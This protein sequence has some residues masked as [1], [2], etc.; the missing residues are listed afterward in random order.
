MVR[1]RRFEI[2]ATEIIRAEIPLIQKI[3]QDETWYEGERRRC[4]VD[5]RDSTV[6]MRV[7]DVILRC[8]DK[9]WDEALL[10]VKNRHMANGGDR[11]PNAA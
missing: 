3:I 8:G 2:P 5:S 7:V 6:R 10:S 1:K 11:E 4:P 9:L